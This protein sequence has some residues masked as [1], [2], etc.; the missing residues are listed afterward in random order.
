MKG[1]DLSCLSFTRGVALLV[2]WQRVETSSL[3]FFFYQTAISESL[4]FFFYPICKSSGERDLGMK[5]KKPNPPPGRIFF[6]MHTREQKKS[7]A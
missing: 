3:A 4:F 1:L 2:K 5:K 7:R 6:D